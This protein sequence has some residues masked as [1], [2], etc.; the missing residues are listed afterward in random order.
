MAESPTSRT[1]ALLRSAGLTAAVVEK[2]I[3]QTK[4]RKDLFDVIDVIALDPRQYGCLGVQATSGPNHAARV[5]KLLSSAAAELWVRCGNR[6]QVISWA[7]QGKG[8]KLW[9]PKITD[10]TLGLFPADCAD[11]DGADSSEGVPDAE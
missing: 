4:R 9:L 10:V 1:L 6:L 11:Y 8:R 5:R 7:K 2:W 3:P